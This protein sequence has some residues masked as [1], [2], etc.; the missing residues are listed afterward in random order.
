[1]VHHVTAVA[2]LIGAID[3]NN[4]EWLAQELNARAE[5]LMFVLF[6]RKHLVLSDSILCYTRGI[7]L[8][9]LVDC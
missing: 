8:P 1:M 5:L 6:S 4:T 7:G 3:S 2:A 9:H